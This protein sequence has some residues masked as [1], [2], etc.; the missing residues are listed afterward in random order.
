MTNHG[1]SGAPARRFASG[2][3]KKNA[4][5]FQMVTRGYKSTSRPARRQPR[6][7]ASQAK[8]KN[9]FFAGCRCGGFS[10]ASE[11]TL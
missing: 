5:I 7:S 4:Y 3:L 9:F 2:A 1:I 6:Q 11:K 8:Y 10:P